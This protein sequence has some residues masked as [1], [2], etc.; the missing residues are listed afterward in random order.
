MPQNEVAYLIADTIFFPQNDSNR[1][2]FEENTDLLVT[3]SHKAKNN[4]YTKKLW[5]NNEFSPIQRCASKNLKHDCEI[6]CE[7][8]ILN[9]V[10]CNCLQCKCKL[11]RCDNV[12]MSPLRFDN[13]YEKKKLIS[14]LPILVNLQ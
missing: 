5:S 9:H 6:F 3:E 8:E 4:S 11:E 12:N 7:N 2:A 13:K 14:I 1:N 10:D